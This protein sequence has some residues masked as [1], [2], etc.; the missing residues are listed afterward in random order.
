L[1]ATH[2]LDVGIV[3]GHFTEL[4]L[5]V[6]EFAEDSMVLVTSSNH[7]LTEKEEVTAKDLEEARWIVREKGSGTKEAV[8]KV[9][10]QLRISPEKRMS[11]SSTQSIKGAVEA[12]LGITLLSQWA[13]QKELKNKE[14]S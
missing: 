7:V 12:G 2:Q 10:Q 3:E 5:Q 4:E 6:E 13:I 1:V 9:F 14:L 8:E 11:F